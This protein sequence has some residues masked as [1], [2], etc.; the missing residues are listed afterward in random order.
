MSTS[1][2]TTSKPT[3]PTPPNSITSTAAA[4]AMPSAIGLV[5]SS[6]VSISPNL[7]ATRN[8]STLTSSGLLP[9][10]PSRWTARSLKL[11]R[12]S[13]RQP[14]RLAW[15][16]HRARCSRRWS[17]MP[18]SPAYITSG[19][20]CRSGPGLQTSTWCVLFTYHVPSLL[21][22]FPCVSLPFSPHQP[23]LPPFSA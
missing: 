10:T 16:R 20:L 14:G 2:S 11:T 22:P 6:S 8:S 19:I 23:L 18:G 5:S 17:K 7:A 12:S 1:K 13:S 9:T 3:G 4:W 21:L 15:N